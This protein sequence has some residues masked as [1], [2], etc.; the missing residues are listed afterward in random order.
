[1]NN[2]DYEKAAKRKMKRAQE[3][4]QNPLESEEQSALFEWANIM[5]K[6][7]PELRL[8][9]HIPNGGLRNK[10]VAVRLTAEGV[11]R[12]VPDMCLPVARRGFHGLYIELKRKKKGKTSTEQDEWIELLTKQGY[13][14]VVCHGFEEA[15]T[16][17]E[18]Y[19]K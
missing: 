6:R 18:Q 5:E 9:Y 10:A 11:R 12:G 13:K 4:A 17:I 16:V 19:L 15:R 14:A 2:F 3:R 8:L 1:M 7:M